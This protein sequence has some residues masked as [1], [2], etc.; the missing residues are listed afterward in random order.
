MQ[1]GLCGV[2]PVQGFKGMQASH[3]LIVRTDV[4]G[5]HDGCVG[6]IWRIPNVGSMNR[7]RVAIVGGK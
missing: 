4:G 2:R 5:V 1:L 7:Y 6:L 3:F